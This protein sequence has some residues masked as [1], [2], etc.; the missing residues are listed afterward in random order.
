MRVLHLSV[1]LGLKVAFWW[2]QRKGDRTVH[3][4]PA[5]GYIDASKAL[6][7]VSERI[8]VATHINHVDQLGPPIFMMN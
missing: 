8:V 1:G 5:C 7:S 2:K 4:D 6:D 3:T